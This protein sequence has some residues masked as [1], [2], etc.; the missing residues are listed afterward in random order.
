MKHLLSKTDL[1][2]SVKYGILNGHLGLEKRNNSMCHCLDDTQ[3]VTPYL[4]TE[5]LLAQL[6][7]TEWCIENLRIY[8]LRDTITKT[9]KM[10]GLNAKVTLNLGT[11]SLL[12][13]IP[14]A[15]MLLS[16]IGM[17]A[18]NKYIAL[19]LCPLVNSG[20]ISS[21]L[22]L[23]KQTGC[24][25]SIVRKVSEFYVLYA[26]MIESNKPKNSV[27]SGPELAILMKLGTKVV[28]GADWKWGDQ[29]S[30]NTICLALSRHCVIGWKL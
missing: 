27:L 8:V 30:V 25:Q 9:S 7:I 28:R 11:Y 13:D 16:I 12:R 1:L 17:L 22:S 24:D 26:D 21:V 5:L 29:V 10:K 20:V 14:R 4:K 15:R 3:L 23:L 19:E 6:A 2:T 18:S